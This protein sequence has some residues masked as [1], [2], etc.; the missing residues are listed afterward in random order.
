[1][2]DDP[3]IGYS[4]KE[5]LSDINEKLARNSVFNEQLDRRMSTLEARVAGHDKILTD[6]L[7]KIQQSVD[8][9]STKLNVQGQVEA[10]L[11]SRKVRG[12]TRNERLLT[13]AVGL[14][15][16]SLAILAYLPHGAHP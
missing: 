13:F 5:I 7:P 3:I 15:V 4:F 16:L 2:T 9:L 10:A 6:Q 11:D 14:I 1:M 12:R 8:D